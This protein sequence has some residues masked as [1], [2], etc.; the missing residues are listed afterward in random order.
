L[1]LGA[2]ITS[3]GGGLLYTLDIGSPSSHWIGYQILAGIGLGICFQT[4]I[5]VGQALAEAEDVA[6]VTA[7]LM[8]KS[9]MAIP[10]L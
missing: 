4:P 5:M 2:V 8:C 7:I 10:W 3:V 1:I 9:K 6:T